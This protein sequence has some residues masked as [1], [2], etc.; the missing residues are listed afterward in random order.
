METLKYLEDKEKLK[1]AMIKN[2][3][4]GTPIFLIGVALAIFTFGRIGSFGYIE[5]GLFG[6]LAGAMLFGGYTIYM[7]GLKRMK[8]S[9]NPERTIIAADENGLTVARDDFI[10]ADFHLPWA[11]VQSVKAVNNIFCVYLTDPQAYI[12][13]LDKKKKAEAVQY[14]KIHETPLIV[15]AGTCAAPVETIASEIMGLIQSKSA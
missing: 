5:A 8:M 15:Q 9:K 3:A 10:E 7:S 6:G 1:S 4:I 14:N 2:L 12:E 13:S 11:N